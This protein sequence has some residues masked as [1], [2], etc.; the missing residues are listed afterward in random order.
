M[1][2]GVPGLDGLAATRRLVAAHP[3]ANV[4]VLASGD[5]TESVTRAI[6][7]GARGY[8]VRD[9]SPAEL[10]AVVA[11]ALTVAVPEQAVAPRTTRAAVLP[12]QPVP[13]PQ[14]LTEREQQV[15]EGM[16]QGKTNAEIGRDLFLSED[17]IK[18]HARRLFRK[19]EVNDRAQAVASGFR[20][21]LVH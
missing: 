14:R 20:R 5:D 18:T 3:E 4:V 1:D 21:G 11:N 10:C 2:L 17:T 19:L 7:G 9:A 8:V 6:A 15:L 13:A 16:A 12:T